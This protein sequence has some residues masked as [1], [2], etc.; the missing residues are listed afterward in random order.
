[1]KIGYARV[2]TKDQNLDLQIQALSAAGCSVIFEEK[3]SGSKSDRPELLKALEVVKADDTLVVYKLDRLS[4]SVPD[5]LKISK[6]LEEKK[7]HLQS[8]TQSIDTS[9]PM[10]KFFFTMLSAIAELER[11]Q[12]V[13][14]TLAGLEAA[15]RSGKKSGPKPKADAADVKALVKAGKTPEQV[16]RLLHISRATVYRLLAA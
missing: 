10:G 15:R 9:S 6:L 4:R 16:C 11:E 12:I 1:M 5:L 2:S 3:E 8:T 7:V 13:E 14:R